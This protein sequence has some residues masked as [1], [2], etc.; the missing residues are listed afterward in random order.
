M[1]SLAFQKGNLRRQITKWD[2]VKTHQN[3]E[4][5]LKGGD[6]RLL[7]QTKYLCP[8][9]PPQ[10]NS[11]VKALTPSVALVGDG[12]TKEVIMIK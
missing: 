11:Y 1:R 12:A 9:L 4:K 2:Q 5:I 8:A 6:K 10:K 3:G 7:L